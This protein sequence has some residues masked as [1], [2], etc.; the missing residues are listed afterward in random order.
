[1]TIYQVSEIRGKRKA[2]YMMG[3]ETER[4]LAAWLNGKRAFENERTYSVTA[5]AVN[6]EGYGYVNLERYGYSNGI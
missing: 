5:W 3:F 6:A 1:M 2:S 4:E